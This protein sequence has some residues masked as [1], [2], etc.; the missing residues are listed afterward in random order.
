MWNSAAWFT[1]MILAFTMEVITTATWHNQKMRFSFKRTFLLSFQGVSFILP[2]TQGCAGQGSK[3]EAHTLFKKK[4]KRVAASWSLSVLVV[5][6]FWV[7]LNILAD[8][9]AAFLVKI[10][11]HDYCNCSYDHLLGFC[12]VVISPPCATSSFSSLQSE[13]WMLALYRHPYQCI[14]KMSWFIF[15]F[16]LLL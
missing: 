4:S 9:Q 7:N 10:F 6:L 12:L 2:I 15:S 1:A 13:P 5:P 8:I 16:V 14:F 11:L 3:V